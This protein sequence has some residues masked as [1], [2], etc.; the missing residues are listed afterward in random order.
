MI[1]AVKKIFFI[2]LIIT[3]MLSSAI[4]VSR[5]FSYNDTVSHPTLTENAAF[6]YNASFDKKLSNDEIAWLKWGSIEEDTPPRWLNHFYDPNKNVGIDGLRSAKEWAMSP[7]MQSLWI[8][9]NQTWQKAIDSYVSGDDKSAF[10]ALGHV[11]HLIED[12]TVPA[13]TRLDAHLIGDPY[14][15]WV[16]EK[17]QDNIHFDVQ[18]TIVNDLLDV[19]DL[20]ASYSNKNFLSKDTINESELKN[21]PVEKMVHEGLLKEC[22]VKNISGRDFCLVVIKT[23]KFGQ[24]SYSINDPFVNFDYFNLLGSKAVS[25]GAGVVK[26]FFDEAE[27]KK[28][29]QEQQSWWDKIRG[30]LGSSESSL[31]SLVGDSNNQQ[32]SGSVGGGDISIDQ[33]ALDRLINPQNNQSNSGENNGADQ[34]AGDS[35]IV[36]VQSVFV[37][38]VTDDQAPRSDL[39]NLP[40][41]DLGENLP[42]NNDNGQQITSQFFSPEQNSGDEPDD[43]N[44]SSQNASSTPITQGN[45]GGGGTSGGGGSSNNSNGSNENSGSDSEPENT[46][47]DII[48]PETYATSTLFAIDPINIATTTVAT[49]TAV[50]EFSSGD[51][52]AVFECSLDSATSTPCVSPMQYEDLS[53][54]AHDFQV[55]AIGQENN[56][57][58][59]PAAINWTVDLIAPV[60]SEIAADDTTRASAQINFLT[61][62]TAYGKI[63]YGTTTLYTL[64][65]EWE[66][67]ASTSHSIILSDLIAGETYHFRALAKDEAGNESASV[68]NM[69]IT[70]VNADHIVI[71]EFSTG[72]IGGANDEW[73]ELYN[74]TDQVV[75]LSSWSIQYRGGGAASF[76]RRNFASANVIPAHGFFL[77]A[78]NSYT[79]GVPADLSHNTFAMSGSGGNIFLADSQIDLESATSTAIIDKATYGVGANLFPETKEFVPA[80]NSTQSLERKANASSTTESLATGDDKWL[81]NS[82]DSDDN[83]NDFVLQAS[84]TPQNSQSLTEPRDSLPSLASDAPWPMFQQNEKHQGYSDLGPATSTARILIENDQISFGGQPIIGQDKI[85]VGASDGLHAYDLAGNSLWFYPTSQS[86]RSILLGSDGVIYAGTSTKI[87][88]VSPDGALKWKNLSVGASTSF[89]VDKNG[90]IYAVFEGEVYAFYPDGKIKWVFDI[91][92]LG[93]HF[94]NSGVGSPSIDNAREKIYI[95]IDKYIYALNFDGSVAWDFSNAS[96]SPGLKTNKFTTPAIGDDGTIYTSSFTGTLP[97]GWFFALN[98]NGSIKW[99]SSEGYGTDSKLSPAISQ[100]GKVYFTAVKY[101]NGAATRLFS[102]DARTGANDWSILTGDSWSSSP[103]V[104]G[105]N[106]Y[107]A[108]GKGV[109]A[110]DQDGNL[111]WRWNEGSN[112]LSPGFG[113]IDDNG[114]LYL[115]ASSKVYR[116]EGG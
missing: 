84:P 44:S 70:S 33:S 89:N 5:V 107:L 97:G 12:M 7:T 109:T 85:F 87:Y 8:R 86:V 64:E 39:G 77:I 106:I 3:L 48:F 41:S 24:I 6:V 19:F 79:G 2:S 42:Q 67:A 51:S 13:H 40:K 116:I 101:F 96:L 14:E 18:P 16:E 34:S 47:T 10:I 49:T 37:P 90:I 36:S 20:V 69:F 91:A 94:G 50:F 110:Y 29:E 52:A 38:Q 45:S 66:T 65:T 104:A 9:G 56:R 95:N 98:P 60:I 80:P 1:Y 4:F 62:E 30:W 63:E 82:Y 92:S 75:D 100:D 113:G 74:P 53:E 111:L 55:V 32:S 11:L 26:L 93:R 22:L 115:A 31:L 17:I 114:N 76:N 81:G 61:D 73:I 102:F 59:T 21:L 23:S 112:F 105:G 43:D 78:N 71:S 57:D 28:Q 108:V 58:E 27:K 68:D 99:H 46:E 35:G 54:G 83:G 103:V 15:S 25:Y 72:G 88:A